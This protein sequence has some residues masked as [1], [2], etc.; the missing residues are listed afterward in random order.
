MWGNLRLRRG[1][2]KSGYYGV[3]KVNSKKRPF[4]AW[5]K[6]ATRKQ[7]GLGSFATAQRAAIEV[8]KALAQQDGEDL[9]SPRK[10][11]PPRCACY[12]HPL[13][14]SVS[15]VMCPR[16]PHVQ[17][18][19]RM[20]QHGT[21]RR[22]HKGSTR[23]RPL[24]CWPLRCCSVAPCTARPSTRS[25]GTSPSVTTQPALTCLCPRDR[26]QCQGA[27]VGQGGR[28]KR[29][30]VAAHAAA[31]AGQARGHPHCDAVVFASGGSA[32]TCHARDG[33]VCRLCDG[34]VSDPA[35]GPH[36]CMLTS[37]ARIACVRAGMSGL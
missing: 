29:E 17:R 24:S 35:D 27:G 33:R 19:Q 32:R 7:Q 14:H 12:S 34:C 18:N 2:G 37:E 8:A 6:S 4:Q 36:V 16:A 15:H 1:G 30:R 21:N 13:L 31:R 28:L 20:P 9:D 3:T 23:S 25:T 26:R 10:Q 22:T 11:K 5:I